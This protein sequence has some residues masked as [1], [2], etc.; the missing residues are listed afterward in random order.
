MKNIVIAI[1][2]I[3]ISLILIQFASADNIQELP[4]TVTETFQT[5]EGE[6]VVVVDVTY[7]ND[8]VHEW[9]FYG[10]NYEVG[11]DVIVKLDLQN[12]ILI[13]AWHA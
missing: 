3:A 8:H 2:L 12:D 7:T 1:A 4:A 5:E 9:A 10:E 11:E 6:G 13:D